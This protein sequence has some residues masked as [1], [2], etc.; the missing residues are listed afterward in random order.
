MFYWKTLLLKAAVVHVCIALWAQSNMENFLCCRTPSLPFVNSVSRALCPDLFGSCLTFDTVLWKCS[1]PPHCPHDNHVPCSIYWI[2]RCFQTQIRWCPSCPSPSYVFMSLRNKVE[3]SPWSR[4]LKAS[5]TILAAIWT[6]RSA[7][8]FSSLQD[9]WPMI[10]KEEGAPQCS[11]NFFWM[12]QAYSSKIS[13]AFLISAV[14]P[15][16]GHYK[17]VGIL[18][19]LSLGEA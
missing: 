14:K 3:L 5:S 7:S 17:A 4:L 1:P 9:H 15:S 8:A 6:L 10:N 18:L 2:G 19:E 11:M 12:A 13:E 16:R